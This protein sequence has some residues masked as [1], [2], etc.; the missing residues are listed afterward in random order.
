MCSC[1]ARASI[2]WF[3]SERYNNIEYFMYVIFMSHIF[4]I[5]RTPGYL[6]Y[7]TFGYI[8][9]VRTVFLS[10]VVYEWC[11]DNLSSSV[12]EIQFYINNK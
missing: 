9:Y 1:H 11:D 3:V 6:F 4:S 8:D 2:K 12:S 7:A 5:I 10:E